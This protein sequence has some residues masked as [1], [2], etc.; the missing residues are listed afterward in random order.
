VRKTAVHSG[1]SGH[2]RVNAQAGRC[3]GVQSLSN[4]DQPNEG[5]LRVAMR[6]NLKAY[7]CSNRKAEALSAS[8][9]HTAE[10]DRT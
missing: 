6:Q 2:E 10:V 8:V 4:D 7:R 3:L 1:R 5:S 9:P